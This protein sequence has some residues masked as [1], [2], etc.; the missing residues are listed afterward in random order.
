[1]TQRNLL[2]VDWSRIPAP[3]DDGGA[4]HL[5][6]MTLPAVSLL[7]TDDTSVTLAALSGRTVVFA[8]PRTGEPNKIA[9]V[10]DLSSGS[11]SV[12][13]SEEQT[14]M[15]TGIGSGEAAGVH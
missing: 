5:K 10:D 11:A 4:A 14:L 12:P 6:G 8:Y 2:E 9:L 3:A 13:R 1:M 7:A 15:A